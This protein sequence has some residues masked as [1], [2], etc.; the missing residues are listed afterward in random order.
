MEDTIV[1]DLEQDDINEFYKALE[2]VCENVTHSDNPFVDI[3]HDDYF[4]LKLSIESAKHSHMI[5]SMSMN[6]AFILGA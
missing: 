2:K 4:S 1:R 6:L 5:N 3:C